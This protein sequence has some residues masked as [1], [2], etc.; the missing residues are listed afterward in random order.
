MGRRGLTNPFPSFLYAPADIIRMRSAPVF[1]VVLLLGFAVGACLIP[2]ADADTDDDGA[3]DKLVCFTI[4][5]GRNEYG[6]DEYYEVWRTVAEVRAGDVPEI[7]EREGYVGVW[8]IW[9]YTEYNDVGYEVDPVTWGYYISPV[10]SFTTEYIS[11]EEYY[12]TTW[13][14]DNWVMASTL[15]VFAIA[16]VLL[17]ITL[18][19]D[20]DRRMRVKRRIRRIIRDLWS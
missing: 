14:E 13:L 18:L 5:T 12:S 2:E 4:I 1:A 6:I 15:I 19:F 20:D 16:A 10:T 8:Y 9:T 7:P 11:I 17:V 3:D